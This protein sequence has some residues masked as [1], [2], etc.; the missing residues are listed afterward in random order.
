MLRSQSE[1]KTENRN[2]K[3]KNVKKKN[4]TLSTTRISQ[5]QCKKL[6]AQV[7]KTFALL[8]EGRSS[9]YSKHLQN[10]TDKK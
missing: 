7:F 2:S 6:H 1:I 5:T 8:F 9:Y 3:K 4:S 10:R